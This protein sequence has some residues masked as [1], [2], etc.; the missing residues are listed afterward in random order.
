MIEMVPHFAVLRQFI[1]EIPRLDVL[2]RSAAI[3]HADMA[4]EGMGM[5]HE[6]MAT[7]ELTSAHKPTQPIPS[8]PRDSTSPLPPRRVAFCFLMAYGDVTQPDTWIAFFGFVSHTQTQPSLE[9]CPV[10]G[11]QGLPVC[12]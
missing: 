5:A 3:A 2:V 1:G 9:P 6:G 12:T 10:S 4:H 11:R 7:K 8:H